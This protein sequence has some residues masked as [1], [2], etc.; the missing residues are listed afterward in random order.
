MFTRTKY[1]V[2]FPFPSVLFF[3]CSVDTNIIYIA[4]LKYACNIVMYISME[5]SQWIGDEY[6]RILFVGLKTTI[7]KDIW[8]NER[9][10]RVD[11][12][13]FIKLIFLTKQH[14][15]FTLFVRKI[16]FFLFKLKDNMKTWW[17]KVKAKTKRFSQ[18]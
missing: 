13:Y 5:R 9:S 8:S 11:R 3:V 4:P 12:K 18:F 10:L 16:E 7:C 2:F 15:Y 17:T 14:P 1:I 6:R